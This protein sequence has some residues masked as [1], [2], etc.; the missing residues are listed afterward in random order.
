MQFTAYTAVQVFLASVPEDEADGGDA[1]K[2]PV[3]W[4][5]AAEIGLKAEFQYKRAGSSG[6]YLSS[7][8]I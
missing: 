3:V 7:L 2:K 6:R 4:C 5:R 8:H 1:A